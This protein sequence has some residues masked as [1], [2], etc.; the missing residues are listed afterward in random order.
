MLTTNKANEVKYRYKYNSIAMI[1]LEILYPGGIRTRVFSFWGGCDVHYS[2]LQFTL[3]FSD[4][5]VCIV[6]MYVGHGIKEMLHFY[7]LFCESDRSSIEL[8]YTSGGGGWRV[9]SM[10]QLCSTKN[11]FWPQGTLTLFQILNIDDKKFT[12]SFSLYFGVR[13]T[14]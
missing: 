10:V 8:I 4:L 12:V 1:F 13:W 9:H 7:V 2:T 5:V 6:P 11:G 3:W 14:N